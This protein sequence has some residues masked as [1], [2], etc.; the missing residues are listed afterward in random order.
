MVR[1]LSYS[2]VDFVSDWMYSG[3]GIGGLTLAVALSK[4]PDVEVNV[5][6]QSKELTQIGAGIG[7]FRRALYAYDLLS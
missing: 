6:E 4:Y 1:I 3:G 5:Y 2:P 7:F